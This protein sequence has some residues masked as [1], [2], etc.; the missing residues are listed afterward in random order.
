MHGDHDLRVG[1]QYAYS[2]AYNRNDGNL[3][4]T[5]AF[6]QNNLDYNAGRSRAPIRIG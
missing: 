1:A 2:G 5:F 6:G 3:N 4:G